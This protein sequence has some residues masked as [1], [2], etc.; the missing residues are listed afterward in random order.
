MSIRTIKIYDNNNTMSKLSILLN[1]Y[2]IEPKWIHYTIKN[3]KKTNICGRKHNWNKKQ[4]YYNSLF[5]SQQND[6]DERQCVREYD[7]SDSSLAVLDI[8]EDISYED[9]I[10]KYNFLTDVYYTVGN[11]KGFHFWMPWRKV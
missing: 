1:Q 8:D 4:C 10:S 5:V 2:G 9:V 6:G 3:G 7:I 11:T